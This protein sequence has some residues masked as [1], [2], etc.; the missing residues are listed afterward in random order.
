[1]EHINVT[2]VIGHDITS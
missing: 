2:E 1:M